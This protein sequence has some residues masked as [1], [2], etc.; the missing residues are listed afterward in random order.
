MD[1]SGGEMILVLAKV[2]WNCLK[3]STER[4]NRV[5]MLHA[6][7]AKMPHS[8]FKRSKLNRPI[9]S[10]LVISHSVF[11]DSGHDLQQWFC[12][13]ITHCLSVHESWFNIIN[14]PE[15]VLESR[16]GAQIGIEFFWCSWRC[17]FYDVFSP[18]KINLYYLIS[19]IIVNIPIYDQKILILST[20]NHFVI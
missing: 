12:V 3:L 11:A 15:N 6:C 1:F 17:K 7:N 5:W 20:K 14:F 4:E 9:F 19:D 18:M 8:V 2:E 13:L 16:F 10:L